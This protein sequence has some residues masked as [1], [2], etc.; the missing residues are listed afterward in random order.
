MTSS[1]TSDR[2]YRRYQ[3]TAQRMSAGSVCRHLKI[4]GRLAI[5][6]FFHVVSRAHGSCN[7]TVPKMKHG[8]RT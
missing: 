3:R 1:G 8:D 5:S 4:V 6:R 7:T 2:E